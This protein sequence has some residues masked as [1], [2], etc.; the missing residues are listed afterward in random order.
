MTIILKQEIEVT[1]AA[2]DGEERQD[3]RGKKRANSIMFAQFV[4]SKTVWAVDSAAAERELKRREK[5][6]NLLS[7]VRGEL[8]GGHHWTLKLN[9]CERECVWIVLGTHPPLAW[10]IKWRGAS[11][12]QLAFDLPGNI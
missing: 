11:A 5:E 6:S 8:K 4:K 9:A 2:T 3:R 7:T 10:L 1:F 12:A